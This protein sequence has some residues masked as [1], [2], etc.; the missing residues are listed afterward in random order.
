L[1][2]GPPSLRHHFS[3]PLSISSSLFQTAALA[4]LGTTIPDLATYMVS[5]PDIP[6]AHGTLPRFPVTRAAAPG[7]PP[8]P[9]TWDALGET[10]PPHVPPFLPA[11][12]DR[13]SYAA[14]PLFPGHDTSAAAAAAATAAAAAAGEAALVGLARRAAGE[15]GGAQGPPSVAAAVAAAIAAGGGA[16]PDPGALATGRAALETAPFTEDALAAGK[17]RAEAGT[18]PK[19]SGGG[20]TPGEE[21]PPAGGRRA[22][23]RGTVDAATARAEALLEAGSDA[24]ALE[25][26]G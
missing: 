10:A 18:V 21:A 13:H 7:A 23:K 16:R 6:F 14:T 5:V 25:D 12:P 22:G 15:A 19:G 24:M 17:A 11:F 2:A 20:P 9:P 8:P 3:Q 26:D 1:D 4:D